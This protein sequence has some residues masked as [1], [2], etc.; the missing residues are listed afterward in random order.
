MITIGK[1]WQI[2]VFSEEE[3][4]RRWRNIR[5]KMAARELDCLII[6][7]TTAISKASYA[8]L[9]YVTNFI[10]WSDDEYCIFPFKGE[11][12]FYTYMI[13]HQYWA[14]KVSWVKDIRTCSSNIFAHEP[15]QDVVKQIK[16]LGLEKGTIGIV[17][18]RTML[19]Y[20]YAYLVKEL[21]QARIIEAGDII[22]DCRRIKSSAELE[23]VRK[24]GECADAGFRAMAGIA[25]PGITDYDL[26][27][28]S[29]A[30]MIKNG[31]EVG[32][33][34]L[35]N[36]KKWPDGWGFPHGGTYRKLQMGDV[37]LNEITPCYGG[38]FVQICRPISLG[39]PSEDFLEMYDIHK[40]MYRIGREGFRAGNWINDV[41]ARVKQYALSRRPFSHAT[42]GFQHLDSLNADPNFDLELKPG[43]VYEIHPWTH[44]PEADMIARKNHL[45]HIL[46]D[47]HIITTDET[48]CVS[49]IPIEITVV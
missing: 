18:G 28:E 36:S 12:T 39:E 34:T 6:S 2:P 26:A 4:M 37:I 20:F 48:E 25:R 43:M 47:A 11:P 40:G 17:N 23:F 5:Q 14:E 15:A 30:A 49:K 32:S 19:A 9:R 3:G 10:N 13:Q 22:R 45:G 33:F 1:E 8:D 31:A 42:G 24:A 16:M 38:Y 41:D 29:E 21:P 7:G 35:F 27:A 44:P 46:G